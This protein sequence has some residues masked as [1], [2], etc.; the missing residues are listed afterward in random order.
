MK[1]HGWLVVEIPDFESAGIR[2]RGCAIAYP[3]SQG[4]HIVRAALEQGRVYMEKR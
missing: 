2:V 1:D 3:L 4:R